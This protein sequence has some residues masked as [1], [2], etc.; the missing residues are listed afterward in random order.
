M[1]FNILQFTIFITSVS[2]YPGAIV[3]IAK[4]LT[5]KG[6]TFLSYSFGFSRFTGLSRALYSSQK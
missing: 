2:V 3:K 1:D 5:P 4:F 6:P